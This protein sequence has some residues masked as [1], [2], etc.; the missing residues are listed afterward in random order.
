MTIE[1]LKAL[2]LE[3]SK[4]LTC[5][6]KRLFHGRGGLYEEW[7]HLTIDSIDEILNVALYTQNVL[8]NELI[9]MLKEF[10]SN[11]GH[12]TVVIQRRYIK[13]SP[14]EVVIGD[15]KEDLYAVENSMKFKL[16]LLSNQ[17]S[18]YFPDMKNGRAFVRENSK[19]RRVLNLFS[20]TCSFSVAAKLG[21][22]LS[23]SN[24]DMSKSALSSGKT[25][26]HL[27][28]VDPRGVSY[29][30][31]NILKSFSRIK[32][33]GPYDLIIIDPPT[34]QRGSFEATKDYEKI[35]KKL[36]E[37]ASDECI[38]LACLNSPELDSNFLISLF[39]EFVPEFKFEKRLKNVDEF[40]NAD[41]ER[42]L[43]NLVFSRG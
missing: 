23:V 35:I 40:A 13:G 9:E 32:Q 34:L 1:Q 7:K 26:H 29:L 5:E 3:N 11:S 20:Y 27:N 12:K 2:L 42:S 43:K 36:Q 6:F 31:Y 30:P 10:V 39:S 22:A 37:I 18:L 19:E 41:E 8:E 24:I 17:N 21:G 16:N 4:D 15:L 28:A 38:V 14:S 25:N 33:N